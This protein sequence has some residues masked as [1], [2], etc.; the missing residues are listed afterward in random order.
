[1]P[2]MACT[3]TAT[4]VAPT[5]LVFLVGIFEAVKTKSA[6]YVNMFSSGIAVR[7]LVT[8]LLIKDPMAGLDETVRLF[9]IFDILFL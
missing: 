9:E 3:P 7:I 1:M 6:I 2:T 8:A 5:P 4:S